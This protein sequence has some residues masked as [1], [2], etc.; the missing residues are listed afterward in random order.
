MS[1]PARLCKPRY[2]SSSHLLLA[3]AAAALAAA[4][5]ALAAA[6]AAAAQQKQHCTAPAA[7]VGLLSRQCST[8]W[9]QALQWQ[10]RLWRLLR[11][12][13]RRCG[14]FVPHGAVRGCGSSGGGSSGGG[15]SGSS[16]SS[17]RRARAPFCHVHGVNAHYMAASTGNLL[18]SKACLPYLLVLQGQPPGLMQEH[19]LLRVPRVTVCVK[20]TTR[21]L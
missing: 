9:L 6:A 4:A 17:R 14:T 12:R 21:P 2:H 19:D 11:V 20:Y 8:S 3:A 7:A 5:A 1:A 18:A 10:P 16:S 15:S 13:W